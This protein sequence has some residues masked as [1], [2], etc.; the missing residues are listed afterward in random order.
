MIHADSPPTWFRSK[1]LWFAW[2]C[3]LVL[4]CLGL[5][6]DSPQLLGDARAEV[7]GHAWVQWWHMEA[8]PGW[9]RGTSLALSTSAWPVVDP[10]TTA[11]SAVFGLL[12]GPTAS[13]NVLF[14]LGISLSFWGGAFLCQRAGG[15]PL[16][17]GVG[18]S[19][20]PIFLGSLSSG[21]TEDLALGVLA[22]AFGFLVYPRNMRERVVGGFLLGLTVWCGL[23]LAFMGALVS[24]CL[25]IRAIFRKE[26]IVAWLTAGGV[27]VV[28]GLPALFVFGE[29]LLGEGHNAGVVPMPPFDDLWR[30]NSVQASDAASFFALGQQEVPADAVMRSHPTY[31]GWV[32]LLCAFRA[33]RTLWW[34]VFGVAMILACGASFRFA[35]HA[36]GVDNPFFQLFSLLPFAEQLNHSARLMLVGQ[37]GLVVLASRGVYRWMR[38]PWWVAMGVVAEI[39]WVSPASLPLPTTNA[40]IDAIFSQIPPGDGRVLVLPIGGPGINPQKSLY[41]QRAH[42]RVLALN[43]NKPGCLWRSKKQKE[44]GL[45]IE[46]TDWLCTLA[47]DK[48]HPRPDSI[49]VSRFLNS[50]VDTIVV[51]DPW[52]TEVELGMGKAHIRVQGG[53]IWDLTRLSS[54]A[55]GTR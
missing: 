21:L 30:L 48:P 27:A 19:F 31:I 41:E 3:T 55:G 34:W 44:K 14:I 49:D 12:I 39:L 2:L 6:Q 11:I 17:G 33:G 32:L 51:R 9:P 36:T 7:F 50:D 23:Y 42:A 22:F 46:T 24:L 45:E 40:K 18:L 37:L 16:I 54:D 1:A 25:G 5:F 8:L 10:L 20:S 38:P 29:R 47:L 26:E 4:I 43:P 52:V 15:S 35:G 13:W 53:A 28:V